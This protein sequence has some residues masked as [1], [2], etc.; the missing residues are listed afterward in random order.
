MKRFSKAALHALAAF[1]VG[2]LTTCLA[3][4][5]VIRWS[6]NAEPGVGHVHGVFLPSIC[7]GILAMILTFA[8]SLRK[9]TPCLEFRPSAFGCE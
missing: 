1:L 7:V 5:A 9:S 6:Y 2:A 4:I 8:I 3:F